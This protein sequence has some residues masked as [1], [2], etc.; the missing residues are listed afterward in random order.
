[1]LILFLRPNLAVLKSAFIC[2]HLRTTN[3]VHF[4][5]QI[6]QILAE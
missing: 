3:E 2:V 5:P 6:A 4:R 1:M